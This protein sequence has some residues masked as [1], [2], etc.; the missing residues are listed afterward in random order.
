MAYLTTSE[1]YTHIYEE[2]LETITRGDKA[3]PLA[4]IDAAISE[5]KGYLSRFDTDKIFRATGKGRN[6]LLLI[7]V[8]DIA[9]WHLVNLSNAGVD[10]ELRENRY[11][12]AIDWLKAVQKGDVSPDL[13]AKNAEGNKGRPVIGDICYGSNPKRHQHY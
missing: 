2:N 13:P 7:F 9:A 5:A 1:L 3:I 11:N 6:S 10:L 4:A 8:K 12:R